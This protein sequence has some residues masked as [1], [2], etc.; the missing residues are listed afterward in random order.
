M[1]LPPARTGSPLLIKDRE[2]DFTFHVMRRTS[3]R[4]GIHSMLYAAD[5]WAVIG[6]AVGEQVAHPAERDAAKSFVRQARE[7]FTAA[8]RANT[9]ETRPLLYYYSFLN[10]GKALSIARGRSGMVGKVSH[11]VGAVD[12]RGHTPPVAELVIQASAANGSKMSAVDELH[13]ALEG[14]PVR[15]ANYPVRDVIAQSVVAHRMWREAFAQ[16]RVERFITVE[17][18]RLFHDPSA[19][20]IWSRIYVRRDTLRARQRNV[21][22]TLLESTLATDFRAV[23][24]P[25]PEIS[26]ALHVFEQID[27][28]TY[29]GRASDVVMDVVGLLR[30][31]LWQTVLATKPYRGYYLYL[32]P[33]G[34]MRMPQWLSIYSTLF[35]LGSLTRYQPVELLDVL[36]GTY[37]PFFREFLETQPTQLLY[38]LASEFKKQDVTKAAIV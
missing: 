29:T 23:A 36:D 15:A 22:E 30:T 3:R 7:Y 5:P 25:D 13:H 24:D 38:V 35:W 34:D 2:L 27:P 6:G 9:I 10:L 28:T 37:G 16:T 31:K 17:G 8:E 11:G 14:A 33:A 1:T 32:S 26:S 19:N 4:W 12:P 20:Q 18:V 21:S